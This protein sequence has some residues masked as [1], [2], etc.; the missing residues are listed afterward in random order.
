MSNTQAPFG[1][2]ATRRIDGAQSNY[3]MMPSRLAA[4]AATF[5]AGQGDVMSSLSTGY[6][7]ST[8]STATQ[9]QGIFQ[10]CEYYDTVGQQWRFTNYLPGTQSTNAD[11]KVNTIS[12]VKQV[13]E[14]Q[15]NGAAITTPQIQLNATFTGNA[16]PNSYSGISTAALDPATVS[17]NSAFQFTIVGL[18][19]SPS[20]DNTASFNTVEV[21]LNAA[22]FN[23]RTGV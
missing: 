23:A 9:A 14:V 22:D 18:G 8:A 13:F 21:I 20:N 2:R 10:G 7:T 12:D 19:A 5:V 16:A 11:F 4:Q 6:I 17:T 3:A 15:S 1:F